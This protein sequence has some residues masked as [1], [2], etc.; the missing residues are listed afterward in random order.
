VPGSSAWLAC[1]VFALAQPGCSTRPEPVADGPT[2]RSPAAPIA[3]STPPSDLS[4]SDSA[5]APRFTDVA[6]A[7][8]L[9]VPHYNAAHGQFR[10]IETMGSGVGLID[11]DGDGWL[12]IYIAQGSDLPLDP[13]DVRHTA[14]LYRNNR[15]GTFTDVTAMTGVGFNGYG[16]GIAAGDYNGDGRDDL[17]VSG[18]GRNALYRNN[19]DGTFTDVTRKAGVYNEVGKVLGVLVYDTD[20]DGWPDFLLAC[21]LEPNLLYHNNRDGTFREVGVEAGVAYSMQGK[22]RAGMGIDSAALDNDGR[23]AVVIG[24]NSREGLALFRPEPGAEASDS[25][26]YT[27]VADA[28]GIFQASLSFLT[29]GAAF[30]DVDLDGWKDIVTA[31]GHVNEAI[32]KSENGISF[33]ERMQLF[34]NQGSGHFVEVGPAAGPAFQDRIVGRGLAVGDYDGDGD[35]DLLVGVNNGPARLLRN[36]LPRGSHWLQVRLVGT[37]SN[38]LGIGSRIRLDAGGMRQVG[39]VRSGSSYC[40]AN[41]LKAY[42]GLGHATR[43]DR[44]EVRWPNGVTESVR[45]VPID[46]FVTIREGQGVQP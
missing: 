37:R 34:H 20:D 33:A 31:N 39:W 9:T 23:E 42:F 6:A 26:R 12:D 14:Q 13:A 46:R 17:F 44:M 45:D 25:V 43:I 3:V 1:V 36:D 40:S 5:A 4:K 8:G 2:K 22:A 16:Q 29:F 41:D 19:G 10:L 11:Y 18:F 38:R 27:D 24:N 7:A 15:D 35:P 28:T 32:D 21:D 30:C